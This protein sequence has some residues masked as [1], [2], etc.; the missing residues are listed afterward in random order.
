MRLEADRKAGTME[1]E[2]S[3][4]AELGKTNAVVASLQA[5]ISA[6]RGWETGVDNLELKLMARIEELKAMAEVR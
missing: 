3:L 4:R 6:A 1:R 2:A 5:D